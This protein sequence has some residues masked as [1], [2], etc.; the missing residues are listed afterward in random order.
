[1]RILLRI[2]NSPTKIKNKK[3]IT[4]VRFVIRGGAQKN[5]KITDALK[6]DWQ[7][8]TKVFDEIKDQQN[9]VPNSSPRS[10]VDSA[11]GL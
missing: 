1:M 11:L 10:A 8:I 4:F 7:Y 6:Q 5:E 3:K 9:K 2:F